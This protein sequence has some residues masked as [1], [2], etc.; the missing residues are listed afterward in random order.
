MHNGHK[1]VTMFI[2]GLI[3]GVYFGFFIASLL[4]ASADADRKDNHG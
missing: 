3:V 1:G 4:V 2:F